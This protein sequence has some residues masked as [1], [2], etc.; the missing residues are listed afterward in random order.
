MQLTLSA[1]L[2]LNFTECAP[3]KKMKFK[4]LNG[5]RYTHIKIKVFH[6]AA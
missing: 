4:T 6:R 2:R 3:M 5:K 1:I